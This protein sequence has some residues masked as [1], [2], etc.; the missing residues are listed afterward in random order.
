MLR[1]LGLVLGGMFVGA[2]TMEIVHEK[3]PDSLDKLYSKM[4]TVASEIKGG[5][6]EGYQSARKVQEP[7]RA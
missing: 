1:S 6:K 3:Y 5:F 7:V 4:G 2:V